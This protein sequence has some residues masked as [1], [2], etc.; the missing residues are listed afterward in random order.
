MFQNLQILKEER[1]GMLVNVSH[2][3]HFQTLHYGIWAGKG[4]QVGVLAISIHHQN[5]FLY[6]VLI[7]QAVVIQPPLCLKI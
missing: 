5:F 7:M 4:G 2:Y 3:K 1:N 6:E